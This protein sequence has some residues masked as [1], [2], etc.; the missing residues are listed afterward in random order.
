MFVASGGRA[1]DL[2]R[3]TWDEALSSGRIALVQNLG[4]LSALANH[5]RAIRESQDAW[6]NNLELPLWTA[7]MR[8]IASAVPS[9][10]MSGCLE[11]PV[12]ARCTAEILPFEGRR[13]MDMISN[14]SFIGDLN[15]DYAFRGLAGALIMQSVL[16]AARKLEAELM[17]ELGFQD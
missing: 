16:P 6:K 7:T 8:A 17:N 12:A 11:A 13:V 10:M 3:G 1:P 14:E 9:L 2:G 5:D 15:R 4:V